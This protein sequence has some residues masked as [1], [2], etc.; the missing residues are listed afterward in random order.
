MRANLRRLLCTDVP[1]LEAW[2]PEDAECFG[3]AVTAFVG[4]A[5]G[6]G[7]ESFDF[8]VCTARWLERN[9]PPPKNFQFLHGTVLMK[10]WDYSVLARALGDLCLHAEGADWAEVATRL[11]RF[12]HWEFA[13]Y[14][15]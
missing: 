6:D 8:T 5:D 14:R 2:R 3:I 10:S 4:P 1:D 9:P 7:E 11:S 13:D 12:G 15:P